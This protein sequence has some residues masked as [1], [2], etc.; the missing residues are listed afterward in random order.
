MNYSEFVQT[1]AD[2][3][4][5]TLG[6]G[7]TVS[8]NEIVKNN[9]VQYNGLILRKNG[10]TITPNIYLN[11]FYE[12]YIEQDDFEGILQE[13]WLTYE[14]AR[15]HVQPENFDFELDWEK[16]KEKVVYHLVNYEKNKEK[17][18]LVPHFRFLDLAVTFD[19]VLQAKEESIFMLPITNDILECWEIDRKTL[20]QQ[21]V[22]NTP[23]QFPLVCGTLEEVI[24]M[25]AGEDI[26]EQLF[27][28]QDD[29]MV[30]Y[31]VS[32]QQGINGSSVMLYEEE[33]ERLA[34]A[35][36][37]KMYVLPSSIH[38]LV[39]V[40]FDELIDAKMLRMLVKDINDKHV[41]FE[42]FLSDHIYLYDAGLRA[43]AV[44]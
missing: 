42:E 25:L 6:D 4:S 37:G 23:S 27:P 43:F 9:N 33:L 3:F 15:N 36:G 19:C 20:L 34:L 2:Y 18:E 16:Q 38:E 31:V 41:P 14:N 5:Q 32:N 8:I 24:E 30:M 10:Q 13:I 1:V 17:L 39:L 11:N 44:I 40:P 26:F 21:A 35:M 7:Y 12:R 29:K 22:S 28:R